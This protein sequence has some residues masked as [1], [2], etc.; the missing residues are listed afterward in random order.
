M[1]RRSRCDRDGIRNRAEEGET[2]GF[3][4]LVSQHSHRLVGVPQGEPNADVNLL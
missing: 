4:L 3:V 1:P 2:E